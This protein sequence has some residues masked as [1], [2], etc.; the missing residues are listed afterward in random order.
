M[1]RRTGE[2]VLGGLKQQI[3][4]HE[5]LFWQNGEV[6]GIQKHIYIYNCLITSWLSEVHG[7]S[8]QMTPVIMVFLK[9]CGTGGD[10]AQAVK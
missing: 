4:W 6:N 7:L 1:R 9:S 8:L 2:E 10:M 5:T 3:K